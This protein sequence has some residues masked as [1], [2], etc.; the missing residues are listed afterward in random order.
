MSQ[1]KILAFGGSLR[2]GSFNQKAATL[3]AEGARAAGAEVTLIALRDFPMPIFD[4]DLEAA[5]G[6]PEN[7]RKLKDLFLSHD[8]L[9][10]ASPEYNS[11]TSAALKNAIDWVSRATS[12]DEPFLSA[13]VGKKA[14]ILAASPGGYGGARGLAALRTLLE[15]IQV[16]VLED[17]V[18]IPEAHNVI[19]SDGS[20]NNEEIASNVR[21]LGA[22]LAE[23][24]KG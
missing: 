8:A 4:E 3:A 6:M 20:F 14:A 10:I 12:K 2:A 1:P 11:S 19:Q 21:A 16:T 17:Q 23:A 13:F 24:L 7:A 18:T 22:S 5:E 9:L 15:N